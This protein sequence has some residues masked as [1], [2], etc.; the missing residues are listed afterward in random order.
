[1]LTNSIF[2]L[3]EEECV[4]KVSSSLSIDFRK[5]V[6]FNWYIG[7][8]IV[9]DHQHVTHSSNGT[10]GPFFVSMIWN[11]NFNDIICLV[12][13]RTF[14]SSFLAAFVNYV[15][16]C[17]EKLWDRLLFYRLTALKTFGYFFFT[18]RELLKLHRLLTVWIV[19]ASQNVFHWNIDAWVY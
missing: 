1:M 14:L 10:A 13:A 3:K 12:W 19:L 11:A 18:T 6:C 4:Y 5:S 15:C 16:T 8:L 7:H 17:R 9:L 2:H